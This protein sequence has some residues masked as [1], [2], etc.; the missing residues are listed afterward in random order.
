MLRF[1]AAFGGLCVFVSGALAGPAV[2]MPDSTNNRLVKFSPFDG[3]VLEPNMFGLQAGTP[4]HAISVGTEIWVSEQVGDRVSRWTL[5]GALIG[6]ITGQLDNI[7]GMARVAGRVLVT[8][9]GAGNGATPDSISMYD[10][11]GTF[12]GRISVAA[13]VSSPFAILPFEDDILVASANANND[14]HRFRLDGTDLG[15]FHNSTT[16]NFAQQMAFDKDG[17]I[18]AAGFSSNN[19]VRLH[20]TSGAVLG[21]FAASGARGVF[22]LENGNV[23]W[24]NSAGAWVFNPALG[25][26]TQVYTGGGRHFGL[27]DVPAG[28]VAGSVRFG[29]RVGGFPASVTVEFRDPGD[30]SLAHSAVAALSPTAEPDLFSYDL[31][32]ASLPPTPGSFL[33]SIRQ[34]PW[35]RENIGP[36]DTGGENTGQDFVLANGDVNGD[37]VVDLADFLILAATYEVDP[38]TAPEADLDGDGAVNLADFLILAAN[39]GLAGDLPNP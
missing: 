34:G 27:L 37:N 7:R 15:M 25:T 28:R 13:G 1:L 35:L 6:N 2:I 4:I 18:L 30:L 32:G 31:T 29:G 23:L 38:P 21:T 14:I 24:S 10:T 11:T 12:V 3:S 17:N 16:L 19:V 36:V 9:E 5:A 22:Q 39:Y 26:S 20:R 8:N 33:L